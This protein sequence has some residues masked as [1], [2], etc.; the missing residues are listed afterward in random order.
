MVKGR[1]VK[2]GWAAC[3]PPFFL[4]KSCLTSSKERRIFALNLQHGKTAKDAVCRGQVYPRRTAKVGAVEQIQRQA[5]VKGHS[6]PHRKRVGRV[7]FIRI[8]ENLWPHLGKLSGLQVGILA[9]V[10]TWQ[11]QGKTAHRSNES[12][13]QL[14]GVTGR[15]VTKAVKRLEELGL[16]EVSYGEKNLR[17]VKGLTPEALNTRSPLNERSPRTTV[18][19]EQSFTPTLNDRSPLPR[20]TV[21]PPPEQSFTQIEHRIEHTEEP[22]KEQGVVLPFEGDQFKEMWSIWIQERKDRRY[23][24]LTPRG[25]QAAL[26]DLQEM[27]GDDE[28]TAIKIIK[29]SIAKGWQGLHP[30]KNNGEQNSWRDRS[31]RELDPAK[32][33]EW[34]NRKR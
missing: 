2:G 13:A 1:G 8:P 33:L 28:Q 19:P 21:H 20:T 6:R 11:E 26:H 10:W 14:F 4:F 29:Q 23:K 9:D 32:A 5:V 17:H 16:V 34:A 30:V 25:E 18:H 24:K 7:N 15:A 3:P 22:R 12:L 31:K 27:S